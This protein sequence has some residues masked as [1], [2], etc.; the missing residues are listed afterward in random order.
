M[1]LSHTHTHA[2]PETKERHKGTLEGVGYV[3]Y[4]GSGHGFPGVFPM[5]KL[6]NLYTWNMCHSLHIKYTWTTL[7]GKNKQTK[8]RIK[9]LDTYPLNFLDWYLSISLVHVCTC[10]RSVVS[11]SLRPMDPCHQVPLSIEFYRQEDLSGL[12]CSILGDLSDPGIAPMSRIS[13]IGGQVLYC[14]GTW[15]AIGM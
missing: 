3:F 11:N 9:E 1:F 14:C 6:F 10:S 7:L 5:S 15:E 12:P 8:T 2:K 4:L 13:C